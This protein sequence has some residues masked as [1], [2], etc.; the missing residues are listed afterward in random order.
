[1]ATGAPKYRTIYNI[2]TETQHIFILSALGMAITDPEPWVVHMVNEQKPDGSWGIA[3][4]LEGN[5]SLSVEAYFALKLLGLPP[6]HP[7]L[8]KA[9]EW[10]LGHGGVAC[11][12]MFTRCHLAMFGLLPW[13]AIPELP[14]EFIFI[15]AWSPLS[16]YRLA[17]WARSTTVPL[18]LLIHHRPVF[19]LP[20]SEPDPHSSFLDEI[21]CEPPS[22]N[23][24]NINNNTLYTPYTPSLWTS[25]WNLDLVGVVCTIA[26][27]ALHAVNGMRNLPWRTAARRRCVQ[28]LLARQEDD[29]TW[30]GI[31]AATSAAILALHLEGLASMEPGSPFRR[32]LDALDVFVVSDDDDDD[33][34]RRGKRV[35]SCTSAGWDTSLSTIGLLDAGVP[36]DDEY[37]KRAVAWVKAHQDRGP[38][39]RGDWRIRSS[40]VKPGG[41]SF[42]YCNRLCPDIDDTAIAIAMLV[43]HDPRA[44]DS[45]AVLDALQWIL[46][47]QNSDGGWGAF[48]RET[49]N[50][51]WN[52]IPFSD[53]NAMVDPSEPDVV[54]HVLETFGLIQ[55]QQQQQQPNQTSSEKEKKPTLDDALLTTM[56]ESASRAIDFVLRTQGPTTGAW[57]GRWGVNYIFGTSS[58][59]C[60]LRYVALLDASRAVAADK[61]IQKATGW[62]LSR[63]N[64]D[65]GWGEAVASYTDPS[66]AGQGGSTPSQTGWA[67]MGLLGSLPAMDVDADAAIARG[68]RYLVSIQREDGSWAQDTYTGTGFPGHMY[69]KYPYYAQYFPM[70]ALGRY[71]CFS[72]I[73]LA[74]ISKP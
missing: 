68:V 20:G 55:Q 53:I 40:N 9:R 74:G 65:G 36:R 72:E 66:R 61:A 57:Y 67:I 21:W 51:L 16:M 49:N 60:G 59:L 1:M 37:I 62:L 4:E 23:S 38:N 5:I 63:Q 15:P 48:E 28:W 45:D 44:L 70:I 43:K 19:A 47:M 8:E 50:P 56:T 58:V 17:S 22:Q 30:A 27:K 33:D 46:G 14:A 2:S 11:V 32:G 31:H 52:S 25:A 54:G 26:D 73:C 12:R 71:A 13:S 39:S 35:Q 69:L 34:S 7:A 29:G 42:E 18:L 41:F 10:I 64:P 24:N 6:T 3:T